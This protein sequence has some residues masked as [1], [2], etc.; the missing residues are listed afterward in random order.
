MP[1][2]SPILIPVPDVLQGSRVVVRCYQ[3]EDAAAFY[4]AVDES[5]DHLPPFENWAHD[6]HSVD[7]AYV[8]VTHCRARWMVRQEF[9]AGI[10]HKETGRLLG[11]CGIHRVDW[12]RRVFM[13]GYWIRKSEV[14]KGYVSE[15]V[16]VLTRL[17]FRLFGANRVEIRM[18]TRNVRSAAVPQRLGFVLEGT[19][20]NATPRSIEGKLGDE[21]VY[22]LIPED[23][24]ALPWSR[25][26]E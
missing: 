3:P 20:R 8:Q 14:G 16:R 6:F 15:A 1:S 10:F 7:D 26:D 17:A 24:L 13:I 4:E 9:A 12:E 11:A 2:T 5:R 23:F 19:L 21:Y 22:A 25:T 18:N